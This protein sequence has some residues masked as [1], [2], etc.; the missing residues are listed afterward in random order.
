MNAV[1]GEDGQWRLDFDATALRQSMQ[2][3]ASEWGN[4][5]F[6]SD[7]E[8]LFIKGS[9]SEYIKDETELK[10]LFPKSKLEVLPS[11]HWPHIECQEEFIKLV[12]DFLR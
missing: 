5:L 11:G 4:E 2:N 9:R 8:T 10:Q 3:F 6:P 1:A 12:S 7:V